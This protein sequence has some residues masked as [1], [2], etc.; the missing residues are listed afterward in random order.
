[1]NNQSLKQ[2][3]RLEMIRRFEER[4]RNGFQYELISLEDLGDFLDSLIDEVRAETLKEAEE[5]V[6]NEL[7]M[8]SDDIRDWDEH[9]VF[10]E[11]IDCAESAFQSLRSLTQDKDSDTEQ[12]RR[13]FTSSTGIRVNDP[14]TCIRN[15]RTTF[16]CVCDDCT[17]EYWRESSTQDKTKDW[18]SS[19]QLG[20]CNVCGT[21]QGIICK[22]ETSNFTQT[23]D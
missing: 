3:A 12:E 20:K 19:Q 2:K 11:S 6:L 4:S 17:R 8:H 21:P 14:S 1:M 22:C 15:Q 10:V 18:T 5:H 23:N 7:S 13:G 16:A 9:K